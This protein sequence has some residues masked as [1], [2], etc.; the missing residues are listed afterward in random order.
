MKVALAGGDIQ[1]AVGYIG[2]ETRQHYTELLTALQPHLA[3]VIQQL[4]EIRF[5][6][7]RGK[8]ARYQLSRN[9]LYGGQNVKIDY[10]VY[11]VIDN[12]GLWK[13]DWY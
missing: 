4:P 12:D 10:A 1:A 3:E 7:G 2:P 5:V 13:I 8:S 6:S 9:E 11:F